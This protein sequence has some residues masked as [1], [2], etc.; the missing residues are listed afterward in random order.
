MK[1]VLFPFLFLG[2]ILLFACNDDGSVKEEVVDILVPDEPEAP[3]APDEPVL[4]NQLL[5]NLFP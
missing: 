3:G 5:T 2:L 1:K 4:S